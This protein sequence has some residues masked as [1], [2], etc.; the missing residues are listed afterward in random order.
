MRILFVGM[1]SIAYIRD[2][3][4]NPLKE[5]YEV[6]YIS[7]GVLFRAMGLKGVT[8][9]ILD[10]CNNK[11]D[12]VF[13]YP[14]GYG[15]MFSDELFD[16]LTKLR[17]L[18]YHAD[19]EPEQWFV[20]NARYDHRY[21]YI[22][23]SSYRGWKR[24]SSN[25]EK[26]GN[27]CYVPWG[28]NPDLFYKKYDI[29]KDI[30]VVFIGSAFINENGYYLDGEWRQFLLTKVYEE[31]IKQGFSFAIYGNGFDKH[32][33]LKKV[34]RGFAPH[35][36]INGILNRSKIILGLGYTIDQIPGYQTKLKHF[37]HSGTG[38]FQLVNDNPE[39]KEI[40][41]DSLGY[42]DNEND[43]GEKIRYFLSHSDEREKKAA[44]AYRICRENCTNKKRIGQV[45]RN[46]IEFYNYMI[47]NEHKETHTQRVK[48]AHINCFE[49]LEKLSVIDADYIHF[50]DSSI[51]IEDFNESFLI[52]EYVCQ[53]RPEVVSFK[54]TITFLPNDSQQEELMLRR[55]S[56]MESFLL[57][58]KFGKEQVMYGDKL[59]K[60]L[61]CAI[62]GETYY[63]YINY[64]VRSDVAS[65]LL[66]G[67]ISMVKDSFKNAYKSEAVV[68]DFIATDDGCVKH[69]YEFYLNDIFE[70]Y[71]KIGIYG[72]KG[73]I[74]EILNNCIQNNYEEKAVYYIDR[75]KGG[76]KIGRINCLKPQEL[77]E[78]H[79]NFDVILISAIYSS[80]EIYKMLIEMNNSTKV[81]KMSEI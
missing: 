74:Y 21:G 11:Y 46:T 50:C 14:D 33:V 17:T 5:L 28:Y 7:Y 36:E 24:R 19:D 66:S 76:T 80:E 55:V 10:K 59:I 61:R 1:T 44:E 26:S 32:P 75:D 16:K 78:K 51:R 8:E 54:S 23:S 27:A 35:N 9:Y 15:Q 2:N 68:G 67:D 13:F 79:V 58:E 47:C 70:K 22:V 60:M 45:F 34:F 25:N 38:S 64:L 20:H 63:P 62:G 43:L 56:D 30:D 39:L 49:E 52:D 73:Y 31:S 72:V 69:K 37:E 53:N 29:Q 4:L 71:D 40:F 65:D 3:W 18:V 6:D 12:F 81:V 57:P 77:V 41:G 42:F 48:I